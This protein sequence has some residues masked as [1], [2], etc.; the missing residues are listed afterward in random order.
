MESRKYYI[1]QNAEKDGPMA[2]SEVLRRFA[3][4]SAG[5]TFSVWT[6]EMK[7][8]LPVADCIGSIKADAQLEKINAVKAASTKAPQSHEADSANPNPPSAATPSSVRKTLI[9]SLVGVACITAV[10]GGVI[11]IKSKAVV[12]EQQV[13]GKILIVQNNAEVRKLALVK[14]EVLTKA[15]ALKWHAS[16]QPAAEA[17]LKKYKAELEGLSREAFQ[18]VEDSMTL[19]SRYSQK[20]SDMH[21]L[22]FQLIYLESSMRLARRGGQIRG[23]DETRDQIASLI[24]SVKDYLPGDFEKEYKMNANQRVYSL[25]LAAKGGGF[26][27]LKKE[28]SAASEPPERRMVEAIEAL[29][30]SSRKFDREIKEIMFAPPTSNKRLAA[31]TSDGDGL[32]SFKLPPGEY[33]ALATSSRQVGGRTETFNWVVGFTVT[34][35]RENA[36]ILGNQNI[37]SADPAACLWP[38]S[39]SEK[40]RKISS[41]FE[42]VVSSTQDN[43]KKYGERRPDRVVEKSQS[44]LEVSFKKITDTF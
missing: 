16:A 35:E 5:E 11:L 41:E 30:M 1:Y 23:I 20:S 39:T 37:E 38:Q 2:A 22:A 6:S 29:D 10:A 32:F 14:I 24:P 9:L 34:S 26:R 15:E 28:A 44:I 17:A 13:S 43:L 40:V 8:W 18:A 25:A 7:D 33:Y 36:I 27:A 31:A 12:A 21:Q 3:S 19:S 4:L 42:S